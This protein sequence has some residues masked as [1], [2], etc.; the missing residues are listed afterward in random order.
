MALTT[1]DFDAMTEKA[2]LAANIQKQN[3]RLAELLAAARQ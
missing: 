3:G 1:S 2:R